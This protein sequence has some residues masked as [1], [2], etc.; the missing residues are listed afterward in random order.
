M[1]PED[2]SA[3]LLTWNEE[4]NIGRTLEALRWIPRVH[5]VDGGSTDAT[6]EIC[7]RFPNVSFHVREF[8]SH[9]AQWN[10][11]LSLA[12]TPWVIHLDADH[13]LDERW[14]E[15]WNRCDGEAD[16]YVTKFVYVIFQRALRESLYPAKVTL[17]RRER[18]RFVQDGHTQ[19]LIVD[20]QIKDFSARIFHFDEKP[21]SRWASNQISYAQREADKILGEVSQGLSTRIRGT[22]WLAPLVIIPYCLFFRGLIFEGVRGWNYTFQRLAAEVLIALA[23]HEKRW[24]DGLIKK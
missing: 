1:K 7:A 2:L 5:V 16:G 14:P 13:V 9:S 10:Y 3:I 12:Q 17:F 15:A 23:I 8:D 18:G 4:A 11:A 6:R 20:G 24:K 21:L 19:R 22:G